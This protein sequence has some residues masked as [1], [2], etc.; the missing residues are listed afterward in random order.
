MSNQD[1]NQV[2]FINMMCIRTFLVLFMVYT[3]FH[4]VFIVDVPHL[5]KKQGLMRR[6]FLLQNQRISTARAKPKVTG[7]VIFNEISL[8]EPSTMKEGW[9]WIALNDVELAKACGVMLLDYVVMN[10]SRVNANQSSSPLL[11]SHL[12]PSSIY[13]A[14]KAKIKNVCAV[15]VDMKDAVASRKQFHTLR[16]KISETFFPNKDFV[17]AVCKRIHACSGNQVMLKYMSWGHAMAPVRFDLTMSSWIQKASS[18]YLDGMGLQLSKPFHCFLSLSGTEC[19]EFHSFTECMLL[20]SQRLRSIHGDFPIIVQ[21]ALH[22]NLREVGVL[23][24]QRIFLMPIEHD[25]LPDVFRPLSLVHICSRATSIVH[26]GKTADIYATIVQAGRNT[27]KDMVVQSLLPNACD[28]QQIDLALQVE[29]SINSLANILK[30]NGEKMCI[31]HRCNASRSKFERSESILHKKK[32]R[33]TIIIN[34]PRRADKKASMRHKM[35]EIGLTDFEFFDA[36]DCKASQE[37]LSLFQ[38]LWRVLKFRIPGPNFPSKGALGLLMTHFKLFEKLLREDV[39]EVLLLEDDVYFIHDAAHYLHNNRSLPH[40]LQFA[41][42]YYLG[43]NQ[44]FW[45]QTQKHAIKQGGKGFRFY[46]TETASWDTYLRRQVGMSN[47]SLYDQT[48]YTYGTYSIVLKRPMI[49]LLYQWTS[50]TLQHPRYLIP[51]DALWNWIMVCA[52]WRAPVVFPNVILPEVRDSDNL[53]PLEMNKF[54]KPRFLQYEMIAKER[55]ALYEAFLRL[56]RDLK[57]SS[58]S[59]MWGAEGLLGHN[60]SHLHAVAG[61]YVRQTSL[62][63]VFIYAFNVESDIKRVVDSVCSQ[64][65]PF[66]RVI[67]YDDKSSDQTAQVALAA[68]QSVKVCSQKAMMLNATVRRGKAFARRAVLQHVHDEEMVVFLDGKVALEDDMVLHHVDQLLFES[69]ASLVFGKTSRVRLMGNVTEKLSTT[70]CSF[71]PSRKDVKIH[72]HPIARAKFLKRL[73]DAVFKDWKCRWLE[74]MLDLSLS[75]SLLDSKDARMTKSENVLFSRNVIP[76]GKNPSKSEVEIE[77]WVR[78]LSSQ[79]GLS[80]FD[81]MRSGR[82]AEVKEGSNRSA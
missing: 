73:P 64:V 47:T 57:T 59:Q 78:G 29:T 12:F 25:P 70:E 46:F 31:L 76:L 65:F 7:K 34:L 36:V 3:S 74:R 22:P 51:A 13:R 60:L 17:K 77:H 63:V 1:I 11:L 23:K 16:E 10:Q 55:M 42:M 27:T 43:A 61:S 72:H 24:A 28:R 30:Q 20:V 32:R 49:K 62:F 48:L 81:H 35:S 5:P 45:T 69:A 6:N 75:L 41:P 39:D 54:A 8:R 21:N 58:P 56:G 19:D 71:P 80:F 50:W 79:D 33:R 66:V 37:C 2:G 4:V 52:G 67:L 9:M 44:L 15:K 26:H 14:G 40:A 38:E 53:G 68:L 18:R 82:C